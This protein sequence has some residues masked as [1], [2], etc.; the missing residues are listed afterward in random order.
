[1]KK[2]NVVIGV[3]CVVVVSGCVLFAAGKPVK[4]TGGSG[5]RVGVFDSRAVTVAHV[6]SKRND[7]QVR[8]RMAEM[9]KA[10]KAGDEDKIAELKAWGKARREKQHKQG[11][12]TASVKDLLEHVKRDIPKVAKEAGVDIIVSKWDLVYQKKGV[13]LVDVTDLII[14]GFEPDE[15]TLKTIKELRKHKPY[16]NEEIEGHEH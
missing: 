13:E 11:F 10:K 12:G 14:R 15:K 1:M 2:R 5:L 7:K 4:K 6:W 8:A 16:S 9:K 3:V